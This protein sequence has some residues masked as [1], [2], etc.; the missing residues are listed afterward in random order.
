[1]IPTTFDLPH[2]FLKVFV[3]FQGSA[4]AVNLSRVTSMEPTRQAQLIRFL[5][6]D[7]GAAAIVMHLAFMNPHTK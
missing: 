4:K 6:E 5:M 7:A 3:Y 2:K 1:M